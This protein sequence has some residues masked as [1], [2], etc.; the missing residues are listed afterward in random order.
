MATT[1]I[2]IKPAGK[3]IPQ[4]FTDGTLMSL[5]NIAED[6]TLAARD[7]LLN[8]IGLLTG[9][10][11]PAPQKLSGE[12]AYILSSVAVDLH[13]SNLVDVPNFLVTAILSLDIFKEKGDEDPEED[14]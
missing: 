3:V 8:M 11:S 9:P 13:I 4:M 2:P 6:V 14:G 1:G 12:Q 10:K 7:A 5:S